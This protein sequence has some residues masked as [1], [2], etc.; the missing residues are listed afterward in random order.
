M[1]YDPN[2]P[3]TPGNYPPPKRSKAPL[4]AVIVAAALLALCV[5]G[6]AVAAASGSSDSGAPARPVHIPTVTPNPE[7]DGGVPDPGVRPESTPS[8]VPA[9]EPAPKRAA[10]TT[11]DDG[12]YEV[13][14]DVPAGTYRLAEPVKNSDLCYWRKSKDAEGVDII[15]NDLAGVGRLQVTLKR[16]QWFESA[17]CGTWVKK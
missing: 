5:L 11:I 2:H 3:I 8:P 17:R 10:A 14:S 15:D 7:P 4:V 13:G 12:L 16:G 6:V 9:P 1:T